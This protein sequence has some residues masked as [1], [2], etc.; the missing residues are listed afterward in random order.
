MSP[1]EDLLPEF[2]KLNLGCIPW[3]NDVTALMESGIAYFKFIE[4]FLKSVL[5]GKVL[6]LVD[7]IA[8]L[9]S[10]PLYF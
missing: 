4:K 9:I 6:Y 8:F 1:E 10:F 5:L 3:T 2:K 7:L